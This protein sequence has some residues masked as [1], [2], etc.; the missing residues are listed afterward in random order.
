MA[1]KVIVFANVSG[2]FIQPDLDIM[3]DIGLAA[4]RV[5]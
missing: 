3:P 2:V 5:Q 1:F 4:A